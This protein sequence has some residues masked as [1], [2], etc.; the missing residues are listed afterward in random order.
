MM[1]ISVVVP[2]F[3]EESMLERCLLSLRSQTIP[4]EI[5]VCDNNS[6]DR[7]YE[8]AMRLAHKVVRESRQGVAYA[9][10]AGIRASGGGLIAFTGADCIAPRDWLEKSAR[11]FTDSGV[12]AC[13]GPVLTLGDAHRRTF[14][15]YNLFNMAL[16]RL[17]LSWGV[18]DANLLVRRSVLERAGLF[19]PRVQMLEDSWLLRKIRRYGK[20]KFINHNYI[21]TS[22]R[23]L[24]RSGI[25]KVFVERT[26]AMLKLKIFHRLGDEHFEP[27]R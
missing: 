12:V 13:Y 24:E 16:V 9:F 6:T 20:I 25:A 2:A 15:A 23:R 4:C 8:I 26:A 5:V 7:T 22:A 17:K 27:V 19:D 1:R 14:K 11:A 21:K 10:N 3:N 18:S